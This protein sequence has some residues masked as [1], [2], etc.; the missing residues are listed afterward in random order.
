M[1]SL[2][3]EIS[4]GNHVAHTENHRATFESGRH[5]MTPLDPFADGRPVDAQGVCDVPDRDFTTTS[6]NGLPVVVVEVEA[7]QVQ[8]HR[9]RLSARLRRIRHWSRSVCHLILRAWGR[10]V[11][12]TVRTAVCCE[13][14]EWECLSGE[15][16][17]MIEKPMKHA[18]S[19]EASRGSSTILF[20]SRRRLLS[21]RASGSHS[22]AGRDME[23]V[24][25]FWI[26]TREP[27]RTPMTL[28]SQVKAGTDLNEPIRE[29]VRTGPYSRQPLEP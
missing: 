11:S 5:K 19:E 1:C 14:L 16:I 25:R 10:H 2:S 22:I 21:A 20:G 15:F 6:Q 9:S 7:I 12:A 27:D 8:R 3:D 26:G 4:C 28:L 17:V 18:T 29:C 23:S 13:F 24:V